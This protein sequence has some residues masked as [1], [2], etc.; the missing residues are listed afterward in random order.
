MISNRHPHTA[1]TEAGVRRHRP[2]YLIVLFMGILSLLGLIVLYAISPARVELINSNDA[3][4]LDTNHFMQKQLL[5]LLVG[6]V[7]FGITATISLKFWH[8]IREKLLWLSLG[9]CGLLTV[10]GWLHIKLAQC[11]Y[12][13][14]RWYDF[15]FFTFQPA[16]VLKFGLLIFLAGFLAQRIKTNRINNLRETLL[17]VGIILAVSLILIIGFQKDMGTG[18]SIIGIVA[19]MLFMGGIK[20]KY[21]AIGAGLIVA[22]SVL[23]ILMTPHRLDRVATFFAPEQNGDTTSYHIT[24]AKIAIG[25][26]GFVGKGLGNSVQAFGYLPEA[27]N[28]SIFAILGEKFGFVGLVAIMAVFLGLLLRLLKITDNL[29]D[30]YLR[31]LVAGVFG[32]IGTQAIVNIGAMLGVFPLTGVTLPFVSFGGTSL[33]FIMAASGLAFQVSRYTSHRMDSEVKEGTTYESTSSRRG[34]GRSRDASPGRRQ[35]T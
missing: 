15:G 21:F 22:A 10:I 23:V 5:Y 35:R 34:V 27:V 2:D 6:L 12:G 20:L 9:A 26:G 16:E 24:Q 4:S 13:A 33:L 11:T 18:I 17:P 1:A 7:A 25:S 19:C 31:L 30:P 8:K 14:C 3:G 29:T 32:W 28:D